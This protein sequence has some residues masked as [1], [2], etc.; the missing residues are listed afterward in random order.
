LSWV[1]IG[2][3]DLIPVNEKTMHYANRVGMARWQRWDVVCR[4]LAVLGPQAAIQI[5]HG[6]SD[7]VAHTPVIRLSWDCMTAAENGQAGEH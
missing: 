6:R 1:T 4:A 7:L 5:A 3:V 2:G